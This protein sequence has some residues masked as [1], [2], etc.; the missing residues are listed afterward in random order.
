MSNLED[1]AGALEASGAYRVLRQVPSRP[2]KALRGGSLPPGMR[3]GV[4]L[5][6]ETTGLDWRR[7]EVIEIGMVAFLFDETGI[8]DTVDVFSALNQPDGLI[9]P[10]ITELTGII[11]EMVA[12]QRIEPGAVSRFAERADLVIAHNAKF[13]RPVVE[14]FAQG[15][16][17][18]AWACSLSEI[19]WAQMGFE[20]TKL[21]YLV[22]QCG[23]FHAGHRAV[24]DC[25]ALLAVLAAAR[26]A[27]EATPF[28]RLLAA[29]AKRRC[30]VWADGSPYERKDDLK[31]R[32]YRWNDGSN[33]QIKSWWIE[34]DEDRHEQEVAFLRDEIY[35]G[36]G[37][38]PY[39]QWLTAKERFRA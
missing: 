21:R 20:G 16:D 34:V 33:G 37:D 7:H 28:Q 3:L 29:S 14:R 26:R 18:L 10:E 9:P 38:E 1:M 12:G 35:R 8:G 17:E 36:T 15:F 4:V 27:G 30:R 22:G 19:G 13:D 32:G 2:V 6:T 24:D 25:H 11:D 31:A 23:W 5:D 39:L